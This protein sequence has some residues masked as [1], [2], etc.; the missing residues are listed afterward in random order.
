MGFADVVLLQELL[1]DSD[2]FGTSQQAVKDELVSGDITHID[3]WAIFITRHR[4][5]PSFSVGWFS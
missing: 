1:R 3:L 2:F 5:A 4:S